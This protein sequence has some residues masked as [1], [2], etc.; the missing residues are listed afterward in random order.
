MVGAMAATVGDIVAPRD[1][2]RYQGLFGAVFGLASVIGPLLGG[3]FTSTLSWRWI[4]YVNVPVG[5]LAFGVLA[6]TLPSVSERVHRQ[7]DYLGAVLLAAGLSGIV[8]VCTFGGVD[9]PWLSPFI[10]GLGQRRQHR[11]DRRVP[12]G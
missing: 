10:I 1:R 2:G 12:V 4:F 11:A 8:L 6:A 5:V 3:F 7:I 9:H